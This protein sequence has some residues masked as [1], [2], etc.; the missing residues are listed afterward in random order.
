MGKLIDIDDACNWWYGTLYSLFKFYDSEDSVV[1]RF[2]K[3]MDKKAFG[4]A[5]LRQ[6]FQKGMTLDE[7]LHAK[8]IDIEHLK[9][10]ARGVLI[11]K[12]HA[13]VKLV[14][15]YAVFDSGKKFCE[16][17]GILF[18]TEDENIAINR[19]GTWITGKVELP[20]RLSR[21]DIDNSFAKYER[22]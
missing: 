21:D 18:I 5:E 2:R 19:N 8:D 12:D 20:D 6:F 9:Q 13:I 16:D 10:S 14:G 1:E 11:H 15:G 7:I 3:E 17:C 4:G 22:S